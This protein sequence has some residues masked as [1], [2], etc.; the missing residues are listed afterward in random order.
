MRFSY[1]REVSEIVR[2]TDVKLKMLYFSCEIQVNQ[3]VV[4]FL[5]F[6]SSSMVLP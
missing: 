6:Q 1:F 5:R 2:R 3:S 4:E